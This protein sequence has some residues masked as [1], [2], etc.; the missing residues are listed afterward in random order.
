MGSTLARHC[1]WLQQEY[2]GM[3]GGF[4]RARWGRGRLYSCNFDS[5]LDRTFDRD[6]VS[7]RQTFYDRDPTQCTPIPSGTT[8]RV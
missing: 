7:P 8:D 6:L 2:V 4:K 3:C 1:R 5:F